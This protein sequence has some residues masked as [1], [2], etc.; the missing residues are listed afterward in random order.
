MERLVVDWIVIPEDTAQVCAG[1]PSIRD[2]L[3]CKIPDDIPPEFVVGAS[4]DDCWIGSCSQVEEAGVLSLWERNKLIEQDLRGRNIIAIWSARDSPT[5]WSIPEEQRGQV[6]VRVCELAKRLWLNLSLPEHWEVKR[7]AGFQSI[8]AGDRRL[9]DLRFSYQMQTEGGRKILRVGTL[10]YARRTQKSIQVPECPAHLLNSLS[11]VLPPADNN[12]SNLLAE[13]RQN[14]GLPDERDLVI[15]RPEGGSR[16]LFSL[17]Y[18]Q[19]MADDG[20]LTVQQKKVIRH[21]LTRPLRIHGPAG[22]GKT[23]VLVL[24]ALRLLVEAQKDSKRCH[25]LFVVNTSAVRATVRTALETVDDCGFL[26][27][28]R[29]D[30]QFLDVETLHG[31]CIREL[32]LET[33]PQY[34]LDSDPVASKAKQWEILSEVV[35]HSIKE[36]VPNMTTLLSRDFQGRISGDRDRLVRDIQYELAI[37]IKGRGFRKGD[38]D[39]YVKNPLRTFIGGS[40]NKFDRH[41]LFYI[42]SQYE[43]QFQ[44]FGVLDSDDVVLSMGARLATSLWDRQRRSFG[45]DYVLVDETHLLNEN[46]RRVLPYL[47]R[48]DKDFLPLVMTFDEAQ[49]IGGQRSLGLET[50]GIQESEKRTLRHVHRSSPEILA[51]ARD[52]IER[53]P[54]LFSEFT[55]NEATSAMADKDLKRAQSPDVDYAATDEDVISKTIEFCN[56]ARNHN[57]SRVGVV[58]FDE[59]LRLNFV[60]AEAKIDGSVYYVRERG[61]VFA[62]VPNPGVYVMTP[63][64]CGGLEFDVVALLGVDEGRVPPAMGDLSAE[65]Y[66]SVQEEAFKEL[67]TAVTRARY[68]VRFICNSGR[69]LSSVVCPSVSTGLVRG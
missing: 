43:E 16:H 31:W 69:G 54:L 65:G 11:V 20:P 62:A 3:A 10:Y 37:R 13:K 28:N 24:K 46:E 32:G 15:G 34:V 1:N 25:I 38:R 64:V 48:G 51:L 39:L 8:F 29:T 22:S 52:L 6:L 68:H 63:E 17:T 19:W 60:K 2:Y 50:I 61:E 35:A 4:G 14:D 44:G 27:T 33:G 42:Y 47:L 12:I 9:A 41:L 36:K 66:L 55:S 53:S 67:Y 59:E 45:Y 5:I 58:I 40:E 26:A 30:D 18:S 49:S 57:Y 7:V 56:S 23:L 21:N